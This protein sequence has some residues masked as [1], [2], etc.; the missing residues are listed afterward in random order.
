M[1]HRKNKK[2][3]GRST[4]ARKAL[5]R[6]LA[7]ALLTYEKIETSMGRAKVM[8]PVV[9]KIITS[10]KTNDLATR[11]RLLSYFTTEQ[12]VNKLLEVIGPRYKER[13]GGYTR[14]TRL[15]QRQGDAAETV[16]VELV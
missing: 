4:S 8:R 16:L 3:L 14:M 5:L 9:E 12:T 13:S 6:D 11:R 1:R 15:G 10:A 2:T 7:T